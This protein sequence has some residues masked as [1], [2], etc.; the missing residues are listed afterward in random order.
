MKNHFSLSVIFCL[1]FLLSN[2]S[3]KALPMN[4][5]LF[6]ITAHSPVYPVLIGKVNNPVFRINVQPKSNENANLQKLF[7]N[8]KGTTELKNIKN[9][10]VFYTGENEAFST[11]KVFA[12]AMD[13][14]EKII[15]EG[16]QLLNDSNNYFWLSLALN[17]NTNLDH[18]IS[19]VLTKIEINNKTITVG[20]ANNIAPKRIGHALRQHNEDGVDTYRIP[21][22]A[23]TNSGTLISVYDI[24]RNSS[25]DLQEDVDIGMNRSTD[26]GQTWEPMKVIMD[27]GEWGGRPQK[28]NGVGDPAILVDHQTNT[29]WVAALWL[30][31]NPDKRA[32]FAS[33]QGMSPHETGQLLLVKSEDDGVSWSEPI[34]ITSQIKNPEW[35]LLLDGPGK[36]IQMKDGTLVFPAQFKDKNEVPHSTIISSKDHGKTWVIGSGAKS[37]T[38]EAQVVELADHSL[39]LN[40][41][42][43]RGSS[44]GGRNGTGARSVSIT[45]DLG[46]TWKEHPTSRKALLEPVCM[47]SLIEH[48]YNGKKILLFSNPFDQYVRHNMTIKVSEDEG[49]TWDEKFH[50]LIDEG[51][52]RG[53]SCMTSIDENTIGI[54]YEGS[55]ADMVFQRI[56]LSDLLQN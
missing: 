9:I 2:C 4:N 18:I 7:I 41:R 22:L 48:Q 54:L 3:E 45:K 42:D 23:T 34:N 38:T 53:Y 8:L 30:H 50:T 26:G 46:K 21:G 11:E 55:Q 33:Q 13:I 15:L 31:G 20:A 14:A 24:R 27:M 29:I 56:K 5:D 16:N 12:E 19:A 39:M 1:I 43:D 40:M 6:S 36:G 49:M 52:G 47:A 32:W 37:K 28:E 35:F 51:R 44:P 17:E 10:T 25:V